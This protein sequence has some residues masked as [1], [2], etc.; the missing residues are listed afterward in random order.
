MACLGVNYLHA[1]RLIKAEYA[2]SVGAARFDDGKHMLGLPAMADSG[3]SRL[4]HEVTLNASLICI[5]H[6]TCIY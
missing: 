5:S 1:E 3:H 4:G 2:G 6:Y